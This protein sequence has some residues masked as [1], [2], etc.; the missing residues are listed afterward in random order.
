MIV[1]TKKCGNKMK[2]CMNVFSTIVNL[3]LNFY[4]NNARDE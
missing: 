2:R 4:F 3:S 1:G